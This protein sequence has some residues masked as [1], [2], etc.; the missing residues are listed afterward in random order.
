MLLMHNFLTLHICILGPSQK[1][2]SSTVMY[3]E[4]NITEHVF[5][6]HYYTKEVK[7]LE[8]FSP[9]FLN[10]ITLRNNRNQTPARPLGDC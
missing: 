6:P 9:K 5:A 2:M 7:L 3:I 8:A 4:V 10:K 1:L